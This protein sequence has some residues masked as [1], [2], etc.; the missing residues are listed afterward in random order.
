MGRLFR[1][2]GMVNIA[3]QY[4]PSGELLGIECSGHAEFGNEDGPDLV[5]AAVS[6]LTGYLGLTFSQVLGFE[7]SVSAADG[8][9]RLLINEE[10]S[11]QHSVLLEG[12]VLAVRELERNYQGWVK[13]TV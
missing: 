13:V 12:W 5:C 11:R 6:A 8:H 7:D 9:F 3:L 1:V 10:V 4:S 2:V